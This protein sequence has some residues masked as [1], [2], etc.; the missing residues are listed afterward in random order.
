MKVIWQVNDDYVRGSK[1]HTT[2]I[3]DE[4]FEDGG[5]KADEEDRKRIIEEHVKDDYDDLGW[6]IIRIEE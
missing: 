4:E 2:T 1:P 5:W 6:L 3:P